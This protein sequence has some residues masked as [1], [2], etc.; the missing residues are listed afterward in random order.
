[1]PIRAVFFDLDD[2]LCNAGPAWRAGETAAFEVL[3]ERRPE[4]DLEAA[5]D[6]WRKVNDRL[7]ERLNAGALTMAQVRAR[8]FGA[9]LKRLDAEDDGLAE[10]LSAELARV[11]LASVR[12]FD[13]AVPTLDALRPACH[14]GV[15]TNGAGDDHD[16][17]QYSTLRHLRLLDLFDSIWI[18]DLVGFRKPD[19]RIFEAALG[20]VGMDPTEAAHVGDS[21]AKDVAGANA[22]GVLSV[23]IW[24]GEGKAPRGSAR[25]RPR[26][27]VRSL[28]DVPE[29]LRGR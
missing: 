13:D 16:D 15:I 17:S 7:L 26:C 29:V 5:R 9:L 18:S 25:E 11:R 22:A 12:L 8:R 24:R 23:L 1:M 28:T 27:V 19:P 10:A 6:V 2:T 20:G 21:L 3:R 14:L 4:L